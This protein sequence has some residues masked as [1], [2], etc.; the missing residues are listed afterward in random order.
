MAGVSE[1]VFGI[2]AAG[3]QGGDPVA[4]APSLNPVADLRNL[5]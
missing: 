4:A 2:T 5:A 1:C 3:Q